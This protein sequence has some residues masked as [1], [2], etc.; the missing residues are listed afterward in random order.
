MI[1]AISTEG[2]G[3]F[4]LL[5]GSTNSDRVVLFL[6]KLIGRLRREGMNLQEKVVIM[7]DNARYHNSNKIRMLLG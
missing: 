1:A 2:D 7:L 4:S 3:F 5:Q 6:E